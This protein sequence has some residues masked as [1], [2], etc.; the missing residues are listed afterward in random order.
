MMSVAF[1]EQPESVSTRHHQTVNRTRATA[2]LPSVIGGP[3]SDF[4]SL[5]A[6]SKG[7]FGSLMGSSPGC[8][9]ARTLA[10]WR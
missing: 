10:G 4:T 6:R 8:R 3:N 7:I 1:V 2:A 9:R 5:V